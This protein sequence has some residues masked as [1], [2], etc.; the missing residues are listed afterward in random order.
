MRVAVVGKGGSGKSVI[1]GT[2]ARVL[3]RRG[4]RVLALDSDMMP[5]LE[6]SLGARSPAEPLL[7]AAAERTE[8]GRWR[9]RRGIGPVRAVQRFSITAPDGVRLLQAGKVGREGMPVIAGAVNAYSQV[10]ARLAK[11]ATFS[12][13]SIVADLPAGPR[14]VAFG[15]APFA[16]LFLLVVE[17]TAQSLMTA[18]RVGRIAAARDGG[19]RLAAVVNKSSGPEDVERARAFL[20]HPVLG[21]VPSD[22]AVVA[23]ERAGEALIDHAPDAPA[24]RAVERLV[25]ELE[26]RMV[27]GG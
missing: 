14:Q 16:P 15:W 21:A 20:G 23:A 27:S 2:M 22:P 6:F 4:G 9:L 25:D 5:G 11:A 13:W 26:G 12:D 18:R 19:V 24:S 1:A 8:D 10:I 3:A 17:P 7:L